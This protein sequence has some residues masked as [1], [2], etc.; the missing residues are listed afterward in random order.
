MERACVL[1]AGRFPTADYSV[2][3]PA[4]LSS[5]NHTYRKSCLT[6]RICKTSAPMIETPL[7]RLSQIGFDSR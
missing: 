1:V 5:A 4:A 3:S 6:L 7:K 2:C